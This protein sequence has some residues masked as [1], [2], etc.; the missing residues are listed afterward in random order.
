MIVG[1]GVDFEKSHA[2]RIKGEFLPSTGLEHFE[3]LGLTDL[4]HGSERPVRRIGTEQ[5]D[6]FDRLIVAAALRL[7]GP[8]GRLKASC[9][10]PCRSQHEAAQGQE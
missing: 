5:F 7:L 1:Q 4:E 9:T 2:D 3:I 8:V 10:P 6:R